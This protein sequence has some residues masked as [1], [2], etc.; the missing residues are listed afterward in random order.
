MAVVGIGVLDLDLFFDRATADWKGDS[1]IAHFPLAVRASNRGHAP[2]LCSNLFGAVEVRRSQ[3]GVLV[4]DF[5]SVN[6]DAALIEGRTDNMVSHHHRFDEGRYQRADASK[7]PITAL[8]LAR[9]GRTDCRIWTT[10]IDVDD[11]AEGALEDFC[12]SRW[13]YL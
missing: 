1:L 5:G 3:G 7:P 4:N 12:E 10:L 8:M 2:I 13:V 11:D 9:S 6:I